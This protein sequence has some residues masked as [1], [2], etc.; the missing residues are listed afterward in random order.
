L[1]NAEPP[2]TQNWVILKNHVPVASP[3]SLCLVVTHPVVSSFHVIWFL[4]YE[5]VSALQ[6]TGTVKLYSNREPETND[7]LLSVGA[8]HTPVA[9]VVGV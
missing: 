6:L 4:E 8:T 7:T 2:K 5:N 3:V 1:E 9:V